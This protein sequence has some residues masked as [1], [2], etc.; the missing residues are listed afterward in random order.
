[1]THDRVPVKLLPMRGFQ[2][3]NRLSRATDW[4]ARQHA[5]VNMPN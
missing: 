3:P 2:V 1:M 4:K 5:A